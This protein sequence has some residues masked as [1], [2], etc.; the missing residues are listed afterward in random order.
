M[1]LSAGERQ[2]AELMQ[3]VRQHCQAL[4]I[5]HE[6]VG[7]RYFA[8]TTFRQLEVTLP[9]GVRIIGLPANPQTARGFTGDVLLDEFGDQPPQVGALRTIMRGGGERESPQLSAVSHQL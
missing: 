6:Y 1:L 3:K 8:R 5:A 9:N 2:S 7:D 4:A